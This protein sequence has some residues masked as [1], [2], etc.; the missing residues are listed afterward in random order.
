MSLAIQQ[1]CFR[2]TTAK[3]VV[4]LLAPLLDS[5]TITPWE[6]DLIANA[7]K[8]LTK[9]S[10]SHMPPLRLITAHEAAELLGISFSQ[11]RALEKEGTFPFKRKMVG[12]KTV[13]FRNWD[14]LR[15]MSEDDD[16]GKGGNA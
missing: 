5:G 3:L 12:D 1:N 14:I 15:Y 13:R 8:S 4:R 6:Y 2:P 16:F 7:M 11:F 10:S 9:A